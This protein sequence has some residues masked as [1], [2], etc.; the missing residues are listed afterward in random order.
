M[1]QHSEDCTHETG[2]SADDRRPGE[3]PEQAVFPFELTARSDRA[4]CD[5]LARNIDLTAS[6]PARKRR[7]A[8][9]RQ[10]HHHLPIESLGTQ[11]RRI[12]D[13]GPVRRR[14]QNHLLA[15]VEAIHLHEQLVERLPALI[16]DSTNA[17]ATPTPDGVELVNEHDRLLCGPGPWKK[18]PHVPCD[19]Q[20]EENP[21][22]RIH[23]VLAGRWSL[24]GGLRPHH[25]RT[26]RLCRQILGH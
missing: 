23:L 14:E 16:V 10:G 1:D 15:L 8:P 11:Q 12:E 18:R 25:S 5:L 4:D 3:D 2:A 17:R 13:V 20:D 9:V 22:E 24:C 6:C 7:P 21:Q 19:Y 26:G